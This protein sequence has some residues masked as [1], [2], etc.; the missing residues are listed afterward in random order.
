MLR[1]AEAPVKSAGLGVKLRNLYPELLV[2]Q[3]T[4]SIRVML[5]TITAI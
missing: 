4:S 3:G 2:G 5:E 1:E